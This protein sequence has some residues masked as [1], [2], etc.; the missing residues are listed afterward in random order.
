MD[1][2]KGHG[3]FNI[4]HPS[5]YQTLT[6][7]FQLIKTYLPL[8]LLYMQIHPRPAPRSYSLSNTRPHIFNHIPRSTCAYQHSHIPVCCSYG[9]LDDSCDVRASARGV[10]FGW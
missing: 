10:G 3:P 9:F 5:Y 6:Q 7:N 8:K 2:P 4:L 1:S